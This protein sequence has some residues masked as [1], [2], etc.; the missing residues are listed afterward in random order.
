MEDIG[1]VAV[2]EDIARFE[3]EEGGLRAAG[4][5]AAEPEDRRALALGQLFEELRV[6]G[7]GILS[8]SSVGLKRSSAG[9]V[10]CCSVRV[11]S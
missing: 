11:G 10:I 1:D 9:V 7:G 5:G 8:P 3:A 4:V 2:H 6:F